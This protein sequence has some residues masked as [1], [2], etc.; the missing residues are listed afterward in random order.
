MPRDL[1]ARGHNISHTHCL[2]NILLNRNDIFINTSFN[3]EMKAYKSIYFTAM[4]S[5]YLSEVH[6]V[7]EKT[8]EVGSDLNIM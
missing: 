8:T 5:T 2:F 1:E 7:I 4:N 6:N 3:P